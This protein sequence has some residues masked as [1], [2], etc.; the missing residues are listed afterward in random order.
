MRGFFNKRLEALS[1]PKVYG[2]IV[3]NLGIGFLVNSLYSIS[4]GG[5][6]ITNLIDI[7]LSI[8][9]I[10]EGSYAKEKR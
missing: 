7:F 9:A 6:N 5:M 10:V 3:S 1:N 2:D 4:L 8:I